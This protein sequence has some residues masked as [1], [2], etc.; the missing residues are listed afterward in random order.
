MDVEWTGTVK[1]VT[2]TAVE[3]PA[4]AFFDILPTAVG[5]WLR[6]LYGTKYEHC[7][8][9]ENAKHCQ[10]KERCR[11]VKK[12]CDEEETEACNEDE[13]EDCVEG[14]NCGTITKCEEETVCEDDG[15]PGCELD[16]LRQHYSKSCHMQE[17]NDYAFSVKVSLPLS[18][19][20]EQEFNLNAGDSFKE[21][22]LKLRKGDEVKFMATISKS[23][24]SASPIFALH[25]IRCTSCPVE[26]NQS[27]DDEGDS[28]TDVVIDGALRAITFFTFPLIQYK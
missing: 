13:G 1:G 14:E 25:S 26:S 4:N 21:M 9:E 12:E 27:A 16:R 24:G 10:V 28:A 18:D 15:T 2:V 7:E 19:G 17:R 5:E 6:C 8:K 11:K 3:N 22:L 23:P 20:T